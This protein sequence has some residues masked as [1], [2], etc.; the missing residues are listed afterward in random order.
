MKL[1]TVFTFVYFS[2]SA[3]FASNLHCIGSNGFEINA[4]PEPQTP[5]Q[6]V[7]ISKTDANVV[8]VFYGNSSPFY[9]KDSGTQQVVQ[10][11][12]ATQIQN[13]TVS[14]LTLVIELNP[15]S[16]SAGQGHAV[17]FDGT[18]SA[19]ANDLTCTM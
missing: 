13:H 8:G 7:T 19:I 16:T 4:T 5:F 6:A 10:V 12:T 14:V 3:A 15:N 11:V 18:K 2:F 17:I 1:L 9:Q